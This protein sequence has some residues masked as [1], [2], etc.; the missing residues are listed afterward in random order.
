MKTD[1]T[2]EEAVHVLVSVLPEP[3]TETVPLLEATHRVLAKDLTSLVDHPSL[4]DSPLDGYAVRFEDTVAATPEHPVRLEVVA[5]VAAGS[6]PFTRSLKPG[7]AIKVF[8]G[9]P[10]P[11]GTTAIAM[12]EH[13]IR[14]GEFVVVARPGVPE[15]RKRGQDLETG[16]AYLRRGTVMRGTQIALAAAM[17]H[18]G[19]PVLERPRVAILATGDEVIEPGQAL[20]PGGVYNSNSYGLASLLREMGAEPVL[21]PRVHDDLDALKASLEPARGSHLVLSSGGVSMGERD[22]VRTLLEQEGIIHFW[23]IRVKPGGPPLCG[24]WNSLPVFGL[25]GNPVSSLVIFLTVV[26][27]A[28][29]ARWGI[30]EPAVKTVRAR[31][32]TAFKG[33]GQKLG[34]MRG[35]LE[36]DGD[37][38]TVRNFGNQSSGVLRSMVESNALVIIAPQTD[39][40]AGDVVEVIRL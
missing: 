25:P 38:F 2:L 12:V 21:L 37:G 36:P 15:I 28:L 13:T 40:M 22:F 7:Q 31:A 1:I 26:K 3:K 11:D 8:T 4:D 30:T 10:V 39:V 29:Y 9:A 20:P 18:A 24:V 14:E 5:E 32:L 33:A 17:G 34:L 27:P 16:T 19:L 6:A 23:R 35:L